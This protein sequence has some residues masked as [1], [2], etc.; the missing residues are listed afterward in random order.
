VRRNFGSLSPRGDFV[1]VV[2]KG[3][4][5]QR[6]RGIVVHE[7]PGITVRHYGAREI[8]DRLL[9]EL[10]AQR[11]QFVIV[12]SPAPSHRAL[13]TAFSAAGIPVFVEK[14][15][16][17]D[18]ETAREMSE[19]AHA[20]NA[21]L[22]VGYVMRFYDDFLAF[23]SLLASD[24]IGNLTFA[25]F[26]AGQYLPDWRPEKRYEESV[27]AQEKL[28]GGV[29]LELSHEIDTALGLFGLPARV[30]C[31]ASTLSGLAIDVEDFAHIS[32]EYPVHSRA[33]QRVDIQ[34]D[35]LRR[36]PSRRVEVHGDDGVLIWDVLAQ[37]IGLY[38]AKSDTWSEHGVPG[39][40]RRDPFRLQFRAF[41]EKI[42]GSSAE[43]SS[44][45]QAVD[46][47]RVIEWCRHS[48]ASQG[49]GLDFESATDA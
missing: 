35:F 39:R 41:R 48:A 21:P 26:E 27:S 36:V 4:A 5:G 13:S 22:M 19:V 8:Q 17:A 15:M 25:R 44:D 46:V 45:S 31:R 23:R 16:S 10:V 38:R 18:A 43:A 24:P 6:H 14:P 1:L 42:S 40:G 33:P 12:A 29:L 2:G 11:P 47:L 7:L 49:A 28:G 3:S 9:R 34:L 30:S 20:N 37:T 32:L